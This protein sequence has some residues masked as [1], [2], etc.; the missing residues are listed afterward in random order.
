MHRLIRIPNSEQTVTEYLFS[1][2]IG[3]LFQAFRK[4]KELS[5]GAHIA[6]RR[7]WDAKVAVIDLL[8]ALPRFY[9]DMRGK[10]I[11]FHPP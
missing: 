5:A 4:E 10:R 6:E 1:F 8:L 3:R 11:R 2:L 7:G 9:H